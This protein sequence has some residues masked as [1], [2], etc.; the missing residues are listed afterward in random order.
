MSTWKKAFSNLAERGKMNQIF[1]LLFKFIL[2]GFIQFVLNYYLA[3][4]IPINSWGQIAFD[5]KFLSL[6]LYTLPSQ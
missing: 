4:F 5:L 3:T 2:T 1:L 6:V